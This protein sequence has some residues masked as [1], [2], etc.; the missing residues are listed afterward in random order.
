MKTS[1]NATG[2]QMSSEERRLLLIESNDTKTD[3]PKDK[4]IHE[5]FED[6]V[7]RTPDAIAVSFRRPAVDLPRTE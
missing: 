3:Y 2:N 7:E 5:L 1:K 4:C 6:Q